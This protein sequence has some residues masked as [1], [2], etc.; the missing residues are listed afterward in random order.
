[1]FDGQTHGGRTDTSTDRLTEPESLEMFD[2]QTQVRW[3]D[4]WREVFGGRDRY[5]DV[6]VAPYLRAP[7]VG[8][9]TINSTTIERVLLS[10]F[11]QRGEQARSDLR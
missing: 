8:N 4:F 6:V 11:N 3:T 10:P 7:C 2:G 1:M 9:N 5:H